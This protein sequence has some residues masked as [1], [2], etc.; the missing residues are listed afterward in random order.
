MFSL[1]KFGSISAACEL[2]VAEY[3]PRQLEY[4][5]AVAESSRTRICGP[6]RLALAST[7]SP[8]ASMKVTRSRSTISG[9]SLDVMT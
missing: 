1:S 9:R 8:G 5:V 2:T 7:R 6:A 3:T 4:F